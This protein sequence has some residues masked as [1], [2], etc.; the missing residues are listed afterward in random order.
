MLRN[1]SQDIAADPGHEC[2]A[3]Q[4]KFSRCSRHHSLEPRV[5][6]CVARQA[7]YKIPKKGISI[8]ISLSAAT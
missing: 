2:E 7:S 4:K 3:G 5:N 1:K 6:L 8:A